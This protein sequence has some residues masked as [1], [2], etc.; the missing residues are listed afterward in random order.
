MRCVFEI[1][2][3]L[4]VYVLNLTCFEQGKN[5][6]SFLALSIIVKLKTKNDQ[7]W[8]DQIP[9]FMCL[10]PEFGH[11]LTHFLKANFGYVI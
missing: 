1:L 5:P 2:E 6:A 3:H 8:F 11:V 9:T 4:C 10:R 7:K